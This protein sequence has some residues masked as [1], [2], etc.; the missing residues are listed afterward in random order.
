MFTKQQEE[1][2]AK[3]LNLTNDE[4]DNFA[5]RLSKHIAKREVVTKNVIKSG[6]FILD[7]ILKEKTA[8]KK[9]FEYGELRNLV[10]KKYA[11]EIMELRKQGQ[12][13]KMISNI[14][15]SNHRAKVSKSTIQKFLKYNGV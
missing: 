1:K 6:F 10:V 12:G 7:E 3:Q 4:F 8:T 2:Y 11:E 15:Y 5:Y 14:I 13:A 9:V